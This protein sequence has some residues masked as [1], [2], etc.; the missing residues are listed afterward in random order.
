MDG[1][2]EILVLVNG[3]LWI[4]VI[5]CIITGKFYYYL[6]RKTLKLSLNFKKLK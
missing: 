1:I 5:C 3:R 4:D 6:N 2:G